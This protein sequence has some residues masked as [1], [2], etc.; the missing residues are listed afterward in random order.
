MKIANN[1]VLGC[2]IETMGEAFAVVEKAGMD[3]QD[4][5]EFFTGTSFNTIPHKVYGKLIADDN[6]L[7]ANFTLALGLKDLTL[8]VKAAEDLDVTLPLANLI[9]EQMYRAMARGEQDQDWSVVGRVSARSAGLQ[10]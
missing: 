6:Y 2:A 7:P 5:Y 3:K 9:R 8:A 10:K 4:F 1:F